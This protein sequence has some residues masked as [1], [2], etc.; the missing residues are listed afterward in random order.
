MSDYSFNTSTFDRDY[1]PTGLKIEGGYENDRNAVYA[2]LY[3][4][5]I[6]EAYKC[7]DVICGHHLIYVS[8]DKR[9][10]GFVYEVVQ[11]I[12][13][14]D[15]LIFDHEAMGRLFGQ[16]SIAVMTTL[17]KL[18]AQDRDEKLADMFESRAC[19]IADRACYLPALYQ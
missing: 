19:H 14:A 16:D 5:M 7:D 3:K 4:A 11:E 15:A 9:P 6:R 8:R 1:S 17:A 13:S 2:P 12:P 18:P 10:D